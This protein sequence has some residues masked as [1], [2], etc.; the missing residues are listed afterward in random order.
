M[1]EENSTDFFKASL[2]DM[3]LMWRSSTLLS[4]MLDKPNLHRLLE[5][6]QNSLSVFGH[7]SLFQELMFETTHQ[8]L[9]RSL[10]RRNHRHAE[11]FAVEQCLRKDWQVRIGMLYGR[12]RTGEAKE[13]VVT[14][15]GLRQLIIGKYAEI[16]YR[17]DKR[18]E[19]EDDVSKA[20]VQD[21]KTCNIMTDQQ[22]QS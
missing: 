3:L 15:N 18:K 7:V 11:A 19:R 12:L 22:Q 17:D 8:P 20:N 9:K 14:F 4:D 6:Y 21:N 2:N 13:Q 1:R 5:L 10:S 16:G